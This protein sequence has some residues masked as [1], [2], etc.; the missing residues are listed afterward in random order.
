[1]R[2]LGIL[3]L[4]FIVLVTGCASLPTDYP[5]TESAAIQD[6]QTTPIGS[7]Y[8]AEDAQHP[9]ESGFAILRF[10]RDAFNVRIAMTQV[11]EK[12]LDLQHPRG[13]PDQGSRPRGAGTPAGR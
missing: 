8:L 6:Y 4:L 3:P 9:G 5:R 2:F 12:T 13:S 7:K 1:M 11:A 10:G